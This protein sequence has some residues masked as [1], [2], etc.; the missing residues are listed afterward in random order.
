MIQL[1]FWALSLCIFLCART[2]GQSSIS[3]PANPED[4][5]T[6]YGKTI[7]FFSPHEDDDLEA[8]GT[9]AKLVINGNKV[10]IVLYTNGNKGTHDL[11]MTSE[12]LTQIRKQEDLAA[13]KIL[14]IPQE[15]IFFLGYDDGML[16]YVP[17]KEIVEKVCWFIRKYRPDAIFTMDP[18]TKFTIW[19]KTDHRASALLT[20]DGA[21]AA[22]YHLYFPEHLIKEGLQSYAV[23]DWFFYES[24]GPVIDGNYKVDITDVAELKWN[25]ACQHTSQTGK[26]NMK[27]TGPDMTPEDKENL[28]KIITKDVDGKVYEQFRRVQESLSF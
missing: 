11:E 1:N 25:A 2:Y 14:G 6:W 28:K 21:R 7:I 10:L 4:I 5:T 26:G 27:Y 24:D 3:D 17:Q 8:A 20:V 9:M 19:H 12:R 23:R 22:A 16:E 13:N 18:G 15:N